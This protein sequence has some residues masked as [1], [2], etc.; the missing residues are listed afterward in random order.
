[1]R[2]GRR[3]EPIHALGMKDVSQRSDFTALMLPVVSDCQV[4][5][6]LSQCRK[7]TIDPSWT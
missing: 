2:S 3:E 7:G 5:E 6:G 1:M 4:Q